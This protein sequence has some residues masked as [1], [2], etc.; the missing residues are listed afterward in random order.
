MIIALIEF[1]RLEDT[2]EVS[3][4]IY[5]EVKKLPGPL[6]AEVLDFVQNLTSKVK[7]E[8]ESEDEPPFTD[9][10]LSLAMRG[11]EREDTPTY[12]IED[13]RERFI[14]LFPK[15]RAFDTC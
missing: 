14:G 7:R 4:K 9:L 1:M 8:V 11:M 15:A 13:L 3:E 2:M 12:S 5:E 6:Q 10:S